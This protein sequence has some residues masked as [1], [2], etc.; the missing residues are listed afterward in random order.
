MPTRRPLSVRGPGVETGQLPPGRFRWSSETGWYRCLKILKDSYGE[1]HD[2]SNMTWAWWK[3]NVKDAQSKIDVTCKKCGHR[4]KSTS[5]DSLQRGGAPGCF[6]NGGVRWSGREG[7]ARCLSMLKDRCG[8]QHDARNM[9]WAWWKANVKDAQ[10]KIDVTCKKCGHRSKSTSLI[11]LQRGCA[12]G[13]FCNG[14]VRWSSREGRARCLSM[15]KDRHGEQHDASNMTWAWWKANIMHQNSKIDVTCK[16]CGQRSKSTSLDKLQRGCAPGCFCNGGVRWSSREGRARCLSILKD[17]YGE[18]HDASNMT[19][20]WWKANIMHQHSKIDVTCKKCGHHSKSTSLDGLQSGCAPGFFCNGGVRWS[21]REGRARCLS[22]LKDRHGEQHDAS[23][24]TW[25]WWKANIM[26]QKSKIDVTCKKCGHRSKSTSLI[27]LQRGCAP[28]CFCNGGVRWSSREG[29]ARC[30]SILKDRYGEQHDARNMTWAWWKANVKVAQ[31][32]I[33]VTCKKCGHRSKSTSLDSLQSGSAPGCFCKRKTEAKVIRWLYAKYPEWAITS[34][35]NGC[36]NRDTQRPL[37]FDFGLYHD[38]ILIELDGEIGH[39][40]RGW[41]GVADDGGVPH[42][43]L[44]KEC[45]AMQQGKC[46]LRLLQTDVYTDCWPWEDFL[47]AAIQHATCLTRPCVLTQDAMH[48]EGGIYR[49]LR[50]DFDCQRGHFPPSCIPYFIWSMD[51]PEL[52]R[53]KASRGSKPEP[54]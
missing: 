32:K 42:R 21:S 29:R 40:G 43:D 51:L 37:P 6:C 26:H 11:V 22:M 52:R 49:K 36:T 35:V 33:D 18:Q 27:V 5:L 39:F 10:S 13:C 31:S 47:T 17:R 23:N 19:W 20:A 44:Q 54:P 15:L 46:V 28:G 16:K 14:G 9:T 2:A 12:P 53:D 7:R 41:G 34:Q 45:W 8:E 1:Q 38:T 30:L 50:A 25:A 4:S 24:M 48:Y 3:A